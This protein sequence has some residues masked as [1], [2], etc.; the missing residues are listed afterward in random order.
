MR[1]KP[2]WFLDSEKSVMKTRFI[3]FRRAGVYYSEDTVT[4]KHPNGHCRG[5]DANLL[6]KEEVV[7]HNL[8]T[9][10]DLIKLVRTYRLVFKQCNYIT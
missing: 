5:H 6:K 3:L 8:P 9:V 7:I 4:R 1:V 2:D 10:N